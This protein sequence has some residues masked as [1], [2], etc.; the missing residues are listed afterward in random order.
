MSG[1]SSRHSSADAWAV[2]VAAGRSARFGG[3]VPKQFATVAGRPLL[4]WTL[5]PFL[6]HPEL[7]GC[8]VVLPPDAAAA[9]PDWLARLAAGTRPLRLVAGGPERGDSVWAGLAALGD[10]AAVVLV[11]DGVRPCAT[12]EMISAVLARARE[13]LG[14]VVARPVSDTLKEVAADGAIVRTV[15]RAGLWRAETPQAFPRE[16]LERAYARARERGER[17]TD[18]AALCER[19][20]ARV[21][22]VEAK[23]PNPKVTTAAD[24]AWVEAWLR[25]AATSGAT[26]G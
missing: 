4:W 15:D 20:G 22:V 2:V 25:H 8:V 23:T 21:V 24:L 6:A 12:S 10:D 9:P 3:P 14:A 18:C 1:S 5:R 19:A 13:G 26:E 7:A 11:H 17:G 16:M